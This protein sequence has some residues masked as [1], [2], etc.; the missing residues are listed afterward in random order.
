MGLTST[1]RI[2]IWGRGSFGRLGLESDKDQYVA[3]E[4]HLP[5]GGRGG[6]AGGV[7]GGE[8]WWGAVPSGSVIGGLFRLTGCQLCCSPHA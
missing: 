2:F 4:C 6:G 7:G 3:V 1:G 8:G 5:G